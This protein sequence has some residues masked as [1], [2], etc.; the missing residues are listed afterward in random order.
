MLI[1]KTKLLSVQTLMHSNLGLHM[2]YS[3]P[4]ETKGTGSRGHGKPLIIRS[5]SLGNSFHWL[6]NIYNKSHIYI[7]KYIYNESQVVEK[8]PVMAEKEEGWYPLI[9]SVNEKWMRAPR[10]RS[11]IY[12]AIKRS[13]KQV[14]SLLLFVKV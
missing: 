7:K 12:Q 8:A 1:I 3:A 14:L 10:L 5:P 9:R 6:K 2:L 11:I 4:L 13:Q